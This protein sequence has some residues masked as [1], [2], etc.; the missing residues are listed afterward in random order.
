MAI[1]L[2]KEEGTGFI[3]DQHR[4]IRVGELFSVATQM[5]GLKTAGQVE[6]LI[7]NLMIWDLNLLLQEAFILPQRELCKT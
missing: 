2:G 6:V 7:W 1:G 3:L 4:R 5:V